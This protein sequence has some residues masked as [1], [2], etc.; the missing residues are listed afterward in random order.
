MFAKYNVARQ[1][2]IE[3]EKRRRE[4]YPDGT[5]VK[6]RLLKFINGSI[7]RMTTY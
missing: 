5:G 2:R 6:G 3:H 4:V 7:D 1:R